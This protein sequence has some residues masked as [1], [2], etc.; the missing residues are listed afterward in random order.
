MANHNFQEAAGR[1]TGSSEGSN[2]GYHHSIQGGD[3]EAS[4]VTASTGKTAKGSLKENAS[5][6]RDEKLKQIVCD[7]FKKITEATKA[8]SDPTDNADILT[9]HYKNFILFLRSFYEAT[10]F[11]VNAPL[12]KDGETLLIMA[13]RT[14]TRSILEAVR[15]L[16][17]IDPNKLGTNKFSA[18]K[19]AIANVDADS[20]EILLEMGADPYFGPHKKGK[21]YPEF[22]DTSLHHAHSTN[23]SQQLQR[24]DDQTRILSMLEDALGEDTIEALIGIGYEAMN[25]FFQRQHQKTQQLVLLDQSAAPAKTRH[26]APA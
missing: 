5:V 7:A 15:G 18:L 17:N 6:T 16:P 4:P 13:V 11:D 8:Q 23:P 25:G 10:G 21:K 1:N 24:R 14:Q 19:I 20:V 12:T 2:G 22:S 3:K 9:E 26:P